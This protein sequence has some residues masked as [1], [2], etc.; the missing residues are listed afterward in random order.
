MLRLC[1]TRC[2]AGVPALL[3]VTVLVFAV[4]RLIPGAPARLLAGETLPPSIFD[5]R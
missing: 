3:L 1:L 5:P 2:L 4:I